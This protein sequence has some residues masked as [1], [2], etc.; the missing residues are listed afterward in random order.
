[1]F[2]SVIRSPFAQLRLLRV[3]IVEDNSLQRYPDVVEDKHLGY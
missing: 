1:M 3:K 2:F